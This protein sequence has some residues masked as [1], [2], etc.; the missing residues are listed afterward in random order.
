MPLD[1]TDDQSTLVQVMAW[2]RQATSHYLSQCWPRS[3][4]PF[5]ITRSQWIDILCIYCHICSYMQN[6]SI[7]LI[8]NCMVNCMKKWLPVCRWHF[9]SNFFKWKFRD[10]SVSGPSQW[11]MALQC[12]TDSHWLG[13]F[14][15]WS[16][17]IA[18]FSLRYIK[19]DSVKLSVK[20]FGLC[21]YSTYVNTV[22]LTKSL[23]IIVTKQKN[24][25][26]WK[27][28]INPI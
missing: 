17:N 5:G 12:V 22:E 24:I 2:C 20:S 16:L 18:I 8:S 1:F 14:T 10:H 27:L 15:E 13:P 11:M 3:L 21:S 6:Q 25:K 9:E 4:S 26:Q 19:S 7:L 28:V 23:V